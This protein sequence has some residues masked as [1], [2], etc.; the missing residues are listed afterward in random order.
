ME[1]AVRDAVVKHMTTPDLFVDSQHGLTPSRSC[2][3][4]LLCAF[5]ELTRLMNHVDLVDNMHLDFHKAFDAGPH[6]RLLEKVAAYGIEG[7]LHKWIESFLSS[8]T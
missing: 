6:R 7:K 1:S 2:M 4:Q 3:S 8:R 5:E